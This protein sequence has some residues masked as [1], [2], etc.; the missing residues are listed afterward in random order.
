MNIKIDKKHKEGQALLVILM[1]LA[2][3]TTATTSAVV[4]VVNQTR[5]T[6]QIEDKQK[7][8]NAAKGILEK[9]LNN[10]SIDINDD[11][12]SSNSS[13][14]TSVTPFTKN[15]YRFIEFVTPLVPK[16]SQYTMYLQSYDPTTH[17]FSGSGTLTDLEI[18]FESSES[19]SCPIIEITYINSN[20]TIDQK[21]LSAD[22]DGNTAAGTSNRLTIGGGDSLEFNGSITTFERSILTDTDTSH[23]MLIIR[24]LFADTKIGLRLAGGQSL[25]AQGE[26]ITGSA[27][28]SSGAQSDGK[29]YNPYP[30]LPD[31]IFGTSL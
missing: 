26:L 4:S 30:Q 21:K 6:K 9:L 12:G 1:V 31:F 3:V 22:C 10:E 24:P 28:S 29:V 14:D 7:A 19:S 5:Q 25:P 16:D 23:K 27:R 2:L 18:F 13:F 11:F 20:D 8:D 15:G 17:T